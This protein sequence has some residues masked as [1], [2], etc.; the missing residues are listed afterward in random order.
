MY[1][2]YSIGQAAER[3]NCNASMLRFYENYFALDIHRSDSQRR[4]YT[5][6]EI[7]TFKRIRDLRNDGMTL[8]QIKDDIEKKEGEAPQDFSR[9]P[10]L[11]L[12]DIHNEL[13]EL[14]KNIGS[15][16]VLMLREENETL[17][18]KLKQ[19]SLEV[20]QLKEEISYLKKKK[21][22]WLFK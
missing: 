1:T 16:D 17:K 18:E 21:E 12:K 11:S 13:A 19:K 14:K 20:L 8:M 5:E 3:L 7:N 10:E 9:E 22:K 2:Y 15:N 6:A 4:L